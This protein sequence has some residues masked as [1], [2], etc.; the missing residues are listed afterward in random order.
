MSKTEGYLVKI[1][2]LV[3]LLYSGYSHA[4]ITIANNEEAK[5]ERKN[6][7]PKKNN[8]LLVEKNKVEQ[9]QIEGYADSTYVRFV[10]ET[11]KNNLVVG[12]MIRD[13]QDEYISGELIDGTLHLYGEDDTHYT[14][15]LSE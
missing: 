13:G 1:T 6:T 14:V 2:I 4:T 15:I 5:K 7:K 12:Q 10:V 3:A 9:Y 11:T 8:I